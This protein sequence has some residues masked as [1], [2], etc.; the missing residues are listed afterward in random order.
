MVVWRRWQ[1]TFGQVVLVSMLVLLAVGFVHAQ[2]AGLAPAVAEAVLDGKLNAI[3]DR[4]T[5]LETMQTYALVAI[6]GNLVAH[7]FQIQR[8][9]RR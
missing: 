8:S 7:L 6:V 5:K 4:V 9:G 2:I 3:A 1:D